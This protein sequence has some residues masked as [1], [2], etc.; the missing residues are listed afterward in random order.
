M[1]GLSSFM[2]LMSKIDIGPRALDCNWSNA[3]ANGLEIAA[4]LRA[5]FS[6]PSR[7]SGAENERPVGEKAL[8][9]ERRPA[10]SLEQFQVDRVGDH[11]V[12]GVAAV[13]V[14]AHVIAVLDLAGLGRVAD[15]GVEV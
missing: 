1:T 4:T 7:A 11:Q 5:K 14:V 10:P 13:Q 15:G 2:R 3:A 8:E 6:A 12:A 9:R